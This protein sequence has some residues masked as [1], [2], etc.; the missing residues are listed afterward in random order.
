MRE[1]PRDYI[2]KV[3][4]GD[5]LGVIKE[6]PD[7]CVDLV[8]TDFPYGNN[9]NY[10]PYYLDTQEVLKD[11]IKQLMP[12]ILRVG[13]RALI[14]C[15]VANIHLYP[16]PTWILA[17]INHAGVGSNSWGF[18]CWQPILAYGEDP[19]LKNRM[20][21]RPDIIVHNEASQKVNHPCPKPNIFWEKL[22]LRGSIKEQD[23]ILDPLMGSGTTLEVCKLTHRRYIGIEIN[24][25]YCKIAEKRL[26]QGVL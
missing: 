5:C 26:A 23:I 24:P 17:W 11:L 8:L 14:T 22:L 21:R 18:S 10:G 16:K 12:E 1:W 25:N 19:F 9:T 13:K 7:K 4:C 3:I 20:G 15:G 6:M 2:N